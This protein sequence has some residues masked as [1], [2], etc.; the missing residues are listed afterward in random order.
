MRAV[1]IGFA[2]SSGE[3]AVNENG[4]NKRLSR[5]DPAGVEKKFS[6]SFALMV[7]LL[8]RKGNQRSLELDMK[9]RE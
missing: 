8:Q 4:I 3:A 5:Y 7:M 2:A 1:P 6:L 9:Y